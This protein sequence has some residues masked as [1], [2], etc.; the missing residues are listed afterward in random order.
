MERNQPNTTTTQKLASYRGL[1]TQTSTNP[2]TE[3]NLLN[4][5][6]K[7]TIVW[8]YTSPGG[9]TGTLTGAFKENKTFIL[10]G[11]TTGAITSAARISDDTI[12]IQTLDAGTPADALLD[13]TPFQI[14]I[15]N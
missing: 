15:Y 10:F 8:A 1:L 12:S 6:Q 14:D 4:T 7:G 11:N 2:P 9:Y 3:I 13:K 5:T